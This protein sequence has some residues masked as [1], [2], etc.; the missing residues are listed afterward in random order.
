MAS[1]E[2]GGGARVSQ[3]PWVALVVGGG[4]VEAGLRAPPRVAP[5]ASSGPAAAEDM[6]AEA[7][8]CHAR[9]PQHA[10][11]LNGGPETRLLPLLLDDIQQE[12]EV[13]TEEATVPQQDEEMGGGVEA[14]A[15]QGP[16]C[17]W[18]QEVLLRDDTVRVVH[19]VSDAE[20]A[21]QRRADEG[22]WLQVQLMEGVERHGMELLLP[23]EGM[24]QLVGAVSD[25]VHVGAWAEWAPWE[26]GGPEEEGAEHRDGQRQGL[27]VHDNIQV[28][29]LVSVPGHMQGWEERALSEDGDL[30]QWGE[31]EE[32]MAKDDEHREE[33]D[34]EDEDEGEEDWDRQQELLEVHDSVCV[35]RLAAEPGPQEGWEE[36][37][38]PE[39]GDGEEDQAEDEDGEG[40]Q[41]LLEVPDSMQVME[42]VTHPGQREGGEQWPLSEGGDVEEEEAQEEACEGQR[43]VLE[44]HDNMQIVQVMS[45]PGP[46][47]GWEER[48]DTGEWAVEG[49]EGSEGLHAIRPGWLEEKPRALAQVRDAALAVRRAEPVRAADS[50]GPPLE[51]L[52]ALQRALVPVN[53]LVSRAQSRLKLKILQSWKGLLELRSTIIQCIPGFWAQVVSLTL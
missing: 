22:P 24:S 19:V 14:G 7:T 4:H 6:A 38:F 35:V 34:D 53:E 18:P 11:A 13:V 48:A 33:D 41:Q 51:Q 46:Q 23:L 10:D 25:G 12:V 44:G 43:E 39:D 37:A 3:P 40:Q 2:A 42:A 31:E 52:E 17:A 27:E 49:E 15:E 5:G 20:A 29:Q 50:V 1:A 28:I 9:A 47:E 26:H 30:E 36:W 16:W 32:Q 45:E 8:I 21:R